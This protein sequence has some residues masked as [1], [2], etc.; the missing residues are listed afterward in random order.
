MRIN[1][2]IAAVTGLS[3]R[4]ADTA[5]EQGRVLVNGAK[6]QAGQEVNE[7]DEVRLDHKKLGK[8]AGTQTIMLNKPAGY[9]VSRDGQGNKTIYDLLPPELHHL[10]PVG[11][12]DKDSS[13]LLLLTND[14]QLA[15]ELTHPKYQKTKIYEVELDKPLTPEDRAKIELGIRV[16]DYISRLRL[17]K[18]ENSKR[19]T[20]NCSWQVAMSE[21]RNRQIR[22]TFATIGYQ[23]VTLHRT[24]FGTY[25]LPNVP[26]GSYRN[27]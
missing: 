2:Y 23:V 19:K 21:G 3:R 26:T 17:A 1:K 9:V 11:R 16:E 27:A 5:I 14:G 4:G 12:L 10:K 8:P 25:T 20:E 22:R 15:Q 18:I 24:A 6:A 7:A 13:G